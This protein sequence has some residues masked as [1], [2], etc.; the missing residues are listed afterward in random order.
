[1]FSLGGVVL[2]L[3]ADL[4]EP[5]DGLVDGRELPGPADVVQEGSVVK[6]SHYNSLFRNLVYTVQ[7]YK[8]II[9]KTILFHFLF[10]ISNII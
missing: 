4:V 3:E 8:P 7:L 9:T 5:L 10:T 2:G 6:P 1:M